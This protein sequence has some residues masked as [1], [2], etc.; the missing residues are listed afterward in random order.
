[1]KAAAVEAAAPPKAASGGTEAS[2]TPPNSGKAIASLVLGL[3]SPLLFVLAFLAAIPAVVLGHIARAEIRRSEGK[4][5]GSG[6]AFTGLVVGYISLALMAVVLAAIVIPNLVRA[7]IDANQS[8]AVATMRVL[9]QAETTYTTAYPESGFAPNLASLGS[10]PSGSCAKPTAAHACLLDREY[11]ILGSNVCMPGVW[12]TKD[13]YR[14]T[15]VPIGLPAT[16]YVLT[17]T[18]LTESS[19]RRSYCATASALIRSIYGEP[20]NTPPATIQECESWGQL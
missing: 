9:I 10:G 7:R 2:T 20:L 1:M 4:L 17:A 3:I 16:D 19:G 15:L 12:C 5:R 6:M 14:F 11:K 18:P 8:A 13:A